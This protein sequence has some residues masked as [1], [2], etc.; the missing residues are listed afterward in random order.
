MYGWFRMAGTPSRCALRRCFKNRLDVSK[1]LDEAWAHA[2]FDGRADPPQERARSYG[3]ALM[4]DASVCRW[5]DVIG[6]VPAEPAAAEV[7]G[8]LVGLIYLRH[9]ALNAHPAARRDPDPLMPARANRRGPARF[10]DHPD[11]SAPGD[12]LG[13]LDVGQQREH[14]GWWAPY[15]HREI[16]R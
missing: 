5:L 13:V 12:R 14:C 10:L 7:H 3:F 15:R 8:E 16:E 9:D 6:E 4:Q 11:R 1:T 2:A